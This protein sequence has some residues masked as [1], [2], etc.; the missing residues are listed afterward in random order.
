MG[1]VIVSFFLMF[2]GILFSEMALAHCVRN[3]VVTSMDT[4]ESQEYYL[5]KHFGSFQNA[6][7]T[8]YMAVSGG[9]D[10]SNAYFGLESLGFMCQWL[11]V[12]FQAFT[13]L[14]VFNAV[15][16]IIIDLTFQ[17]ASTVKEFVIHQEID[18]QE[19]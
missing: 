2:F 3:A 1:V 16:A 17:R 19:E 4:A 14:L 8:L 13:V 12:L 7:L 5:C 10:W 11:F 6:V 18:S 15:T 9:D